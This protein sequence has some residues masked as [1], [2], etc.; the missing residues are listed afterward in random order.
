[1]SINSKMHKL[2][3]GIQGDW[4]SWRGRGA[5]PFVG[6]TVILRMTVGQSPYKAK[7]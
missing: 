1:M 2:T 5:E 3:M 4:S 7:V 6:E